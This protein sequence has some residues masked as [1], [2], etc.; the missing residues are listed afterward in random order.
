M[1]NTK[2]MVLYSPWCMQ[3]NKQTE[4]YSMGVW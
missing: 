3:N 2:Q 4:L 1:E